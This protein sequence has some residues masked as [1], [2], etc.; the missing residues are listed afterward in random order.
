M[1]TAAYDVGA[2]Q[3][4]PTKASHVTPPSTFGPSPPWSPKDDSLSEPMDG[5]DGAVAGGDPEP[6]QHHPAPEEVSTHK[7]A[8]KSPPAPA[9]GLSAMLRNAAMPPLP[10]SGIHGPAA[11]A[12]KAAPGAPGPAGAPISIVSPYPVVFTTFFQGPPGPGVNSGPM[13][14]LV[15]S[16]PVPAPAVRK[17]SVASPAPPHPASRAHPLPTTP[18]VPDRRSAHA[19]ATTAGSS[20]LGRSPPLGA[21]APRSASRRSAAGV[22]S[23]LKAVQGGAVSKSGGVKF[24]GVRQRP[25]GKFAAEIRDP[26]KGARLWLGTFDTAEEAAR[27]YDRAARQIRGPRAVTN[28]PDEGDDDGFGRF[29]TAAALASSAP[30]APAFTYRRGAPAAGHSPI[31][32]SG[33]DHGDGDEDDGPVRRSARRMEKRKNSEQREMEELADAL[34]LL[35]GVDMQEDAMEDE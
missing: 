26:N 20:P 18:A 32:S 35:G 25:W 4:P 30:A 12:L 33:D 27:A 7:I 11:G 3:A 1:M 14:M 19:A 8:A 6:A 10:V 16:A 21:S 34:L 9:G 23:A 5:A 28:F 29:P 22:S 17:P 15:G 31:L 24:R 2:V 13:P